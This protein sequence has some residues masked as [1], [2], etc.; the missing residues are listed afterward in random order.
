MMPVNGKEVRNENRYY[1]Y[2]AAVVEDGA[3]RKRFRP[4]IR[5]WGDSG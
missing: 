3:S 4:S 5:R 1:I 2:E